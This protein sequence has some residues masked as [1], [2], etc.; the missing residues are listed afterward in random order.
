MFPHD[1]S[2]SSPPGCYLTHS[3]IKLSLHCSTPSS[4]G[5]PEHILMVQEV[6]WRC[7]PRA[8]V[9]TPAILPALSQ[10]SLHLE[11]WGV[12]SHQL[13]EKELK[14]SLQ[15]ALHDMVP[16]GRQLQHY[17]FFLGY[18]WKTVVKGNLPRGQNLAQGTRLFILLERKNGQTCD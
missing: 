11:L 3:A 4:N 18:S 9:P 5:V 14:L 2:C 7:S 17:S 16:E 15:M 13:T 12:P 1:L 6:P 10:A 8:Q